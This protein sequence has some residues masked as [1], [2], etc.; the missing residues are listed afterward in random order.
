MAYYLFNNK[1]E[2][3][4]YYRKLSVQLPQLPG[5]DVDTEAKNLIFLALGNVDTA[6]ELLAWA[7]SYQDAGRPQIE[8]IPDGV[9]MKIEQI[10]EKTEENKR[11]ETLEWISNKSIDSGYEIIA[12][13][14]CA[15]WIDMLSIL[16]DVNAARDVIV[17]Y[18]SLAETKLGS[19]LINY[20][21]GLCLV[22][23]G[24]QDEGIAYI[25]KACVCND[26][27]MASAVMLNACASLAELR[28]KRG[29]R[30]GAVDILLKIV[31]HPDFGYCYT[32][33]GRGAAYGTLAYAYW[34]ADEKEKAVREL[35]KVE[36]II[37]EHR[38]KR[39]DDFKNL[40]MRFCV[41]STYMASDVTNRPIGVGNAKPDYGLF[42]K[43]APSL[44]NVYKPERN[45]TVLSML[46]QL[47]EMVLADEETSIEIIE[48][49]FEMQKT[50]AANQA[51]LLAMLMQAFPLFASNNRMDMLE[52]TVLTS[53]AGVK[54][55]P[56]TVPLNYCSSIMVN[57]IA[58]LTMKRIIIMSEHKGVDDDLFFEMIE[59]A[60]PLLPQ[61][62]NLDTLVS[63]LEAKAPDYSRLNA[64]HHRSIVMTYHLKD[65]TPEMGLTSLY[66]LAKTLLDTNKFP[67]AVKYC[68]L[69]VKAFAY[70]LIKENH[71]RFN[72]E[73]KDFER[74]FKKAEMKHGIG[75]LRSVMEGLYF[76]LKKEP[77]LDK[78]IMNFIGI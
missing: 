54:K 44:L 20:S 5:V 61:H 63:G 64:L 69:F 60:L 46:Y 36:R 68:D 50:D 75:F 32:D 37:W 11:L 24:Y 67:S 74:Y 17:K 78:D 34:M 30:I 71:S 48:H 16:K 76:K 25:E 52:Y 10:Y 73:L 62:H 40:S 42:T 66:V 26:M 72:L 59:K 2:K 19:L 29:D 8:L 41:L 28:A 51:S 70:V 12:A 9:I 6:E 31:N 49:M 53:L 22:N 1:V 14:A 3:L 23:N 7:K 13:V 21:Y 33:F 55:S 45:F 18:C 65:I 47:T 58:A 39:D 15:R 56:N 43:V 57:A 38:N 35:L 27:S 77:V 4:P